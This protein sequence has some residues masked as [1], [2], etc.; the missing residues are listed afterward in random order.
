M[1]FNSAFLGGRLRGVDTVKSTGDI[2]PGYQS[3]VVNFV[4]DF[5]LDVDL[6]TGPY[7]SV[8]TG[9]GY[10]YS[11]II[12]YGLPNNPLS[13]W[14]QARA[15]IQSDANLNSALSTLLGIQNPTA[16]DLAL[17]AGMTFEQALSVIFASA[18]F[19]AQFSGDTA[20]PDTDGDGSSDY[21]EVLLGT[22]PSDIFNAPLSLIHI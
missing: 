11:K 18:E 10:P 7:A 9:D 13:S 20:S 16:S 4:A 12:Y 22:D 6:T 2:I 5:A 8:T 19:A 21:F 3:N 1:T 15:E 14:D 17:Y